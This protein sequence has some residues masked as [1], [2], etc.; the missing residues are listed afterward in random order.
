MLKVVTIILDIDKRNKILE[1]RDK[2]E[3]LN[4]AKSVAAGS[5]INV[6]D[7]IDMYEQKLKE[8]CSINYPISEKIEC[9]KLNIF[10]LSKYIDF[11]NGDT[12]ILPYFNNTKYWIKIVI[13]NKEEFMNY[14]FKKGCFN[15]FSIICLNKK[16]IY[17]IELGELEYEIRIYNY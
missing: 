3:L 13:G 16:V 6:I 12:I 1:K 7:P 17:D 9:K 2:K 10:E 14:M 5:D 11:N 8:M 4:Y 15:S